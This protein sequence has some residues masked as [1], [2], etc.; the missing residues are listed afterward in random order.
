MTQAKNNKLRIIGGMWRRRIL[1]FDDDP[2]L[3]PTPDRVRETLFN[4]LQLSIEGRV[5]LDCFAGSGALSFEA[6][7]RG[8]ARADLLESSPSILASLRDN[9]HQLQAD[10]AHVFRC[11]FPSVPDVV[12][13]NQYDLVFLDPPFAQGLVEQSLVWLINNE[14]LKSGAY[15]YVET[16]KTL[17]SISWPNDFVEKKQAKA[18]KVCYYLLQYQV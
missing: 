12:L 16:E 18:S 7:S 1:R 2:M 17:N 4:W 13:K 5:C 8:A 11:H 15:V 9:V 3:R 10:Q 6:L 14:M